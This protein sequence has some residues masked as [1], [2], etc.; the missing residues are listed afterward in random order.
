M[1]GEL[2]TFF[3]HLTVL[4]MIYILHA[5]FSLLSPSFNNTN[6]E[7]RHPQLVQNLIVPIILVNC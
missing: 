6:L 3:Q 1:R 7:R 4:L 5:I 2:P